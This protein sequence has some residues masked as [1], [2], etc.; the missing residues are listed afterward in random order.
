[1]TSQAQ[2]ICYDVVIAITKQTLEHSRNGRHKNN[3]SLRLLNAVGSAEPKVYQ[4][5]INWNPELRSNEAG[6]SK[7]VYDPEAG[8]YDAEMVEFADKLIK[9]ASVKLANEQPGSKIILPAYGPKPYEYH[10]WDSHTP[11][12]KVHEQLQ[13]LCV[14]A[15]KELEATGDKEAIRDLPYDAKTLPDVGFSSH[16]WN[17][18]DCGK[19]GEY[20]LRIGLEKVSKAYGQYVVNFVTFDKFNSFITRSANAE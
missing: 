9:L 12:T 16:R 11:Q 6:Y 4:T 19:S 14:Q 2:L 15:W 20:V 13:E 5:K 7:W 1:M 17:V 3:L 18:V 8:H 10:K